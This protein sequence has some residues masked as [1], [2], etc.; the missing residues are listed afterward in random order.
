MCV[1]LESR[2]SHHRRDISG[3]TRRRDC[4]RLDEHPSTHRNRLHP[5]AGADGGSVRTRV[6]PRHGE[7]GHVPNQACGAERAHAKH[8]LHDPGQPG[9]AG[10]QATGASGKLRW[11]SIGSTRGRAAII[12]DRPTI[13]GIGWSALTEA[14]FS[15]RYYGILVLQTNIFWPGITNSGLISNASKRWTSSESKGIS[16]TL[17]EWHILQNLKLRRE[18]S[19][20]TLACLLFGMKRMFDYRDLSLQQFIPTFNIICPANTFDKRHLFQS[21][22]VKARFVGTESRG[23][24]MNIADLWDNVG[25]WALSIF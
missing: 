5:R 21:T 18:D 20:L 4:G 19:Y 25:N 10:R 9:G 23:A 24:G 16:A 1:E 6:D 3:Y 14:W 15:R 22:V 17:P 11:A 8:P 7:A 12:E 13:S 2:S